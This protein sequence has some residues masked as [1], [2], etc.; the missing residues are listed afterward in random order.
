METNYFRITAYHPEKDFCMI[1]DTYGLFEKKWQFSADL[2]KRGFKIVEVS[3]IEQIIDVNIT[4]VEEPDYD[5]F[6][7]RANEHGKPHYI[8][9]QVNGVTYKAIQV[10]DKIYIPDNTQTL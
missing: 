5:R 10:E 1:M 4:R 7:L 9:Q 2:V 3:S 6:I 8:E